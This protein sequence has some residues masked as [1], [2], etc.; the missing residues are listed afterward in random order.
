MPRMVPIMKE[1]LHMSELRRVQ[2]LSAVTLFC[3]AALV[4]PLAAAESLS[5]AGYLMGPEDTLEIAVWKEESLQREVL[6]RPDGMISFP[7]LGDLQAAG[8][9]PSQ[10]KAEITKKLKKYIPAPVVTV[11]VVKVAGYKIYVI[12]Q[13]KKAG[14]FQVGRY[15]DVMQALALAGGLTPFA[16]ENNIIILR[17]KNGRETVLGFE[18]AAVKKG[19]KLD[20]NIV[21]ESGDVVVVP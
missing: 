6:V 8:R 18:Y 3:M 14:Q 11:M 16:S 13:V 10:L 12:G 20:Q 19:R 21:L 7:L 1:M 5:T 2:L 9:T 15:L 17:R 4:A